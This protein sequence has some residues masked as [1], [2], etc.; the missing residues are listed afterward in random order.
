[1]ESVLPSFQIEWLDLTDGEL[2]LHVMALWLGCL[3]ESKEIP[4]HKLS[5]DI[6]KSFVEQTHTFISD[7]DP[8][9]E[10]IFH[11]IAQG[12]IERGGRLF[13]QWM[14]KGALNMAALDEAVTGRRRQRANAQRPRKKKTLHLLIEKYLQKNTAATENDVVNM[15]KKDK[16]NGIVDSVDDLEI[17]WRDEED[18]RQVTKR[19][20]LK[21]IIHRLKKKLSQ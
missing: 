3:A 2:A 15:L 5:E 9:L 1:M 20:A 6:A 18:R 19:S 8:A 17:T 21:D 10:R 16:G 7:K 11:I 14:G 12:E 13:R 4:S